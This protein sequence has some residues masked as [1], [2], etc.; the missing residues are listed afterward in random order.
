MI[1]RMC[2]GSTGENKLTPEITQ[3]VLSDARY[4][5]DFA[6]YLISFVGFAHAVESTRG[7][8]SQYRSADSV[9]FSCKQNPSDWYWLPAPLMA[10][11]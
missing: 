6:S 10:S 2:I 3:Q 1:V 11:S 7:E 5:L 4:F 8:A 9:R